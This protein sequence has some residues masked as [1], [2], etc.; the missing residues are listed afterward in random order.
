[1]ILPLEIRYIILEFAYGTPKQQYRKAMSQL[2]ELSCQFTE[3][4]YINN[5]FFFMADQ[6][7]DDRKHWNSIWYT[8]LYK[9]FFTKMSAQRLKNSNIPIRHIHRLFVNFSKSNGF[10]LMINPLF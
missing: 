4:S 5:I 6:V 2:R 3:N 8:Y 9:I 7:K 10:G 1:M